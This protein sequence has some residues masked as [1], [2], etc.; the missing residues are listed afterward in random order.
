MQMSFNPCITL[1]GRTSGRFYI[2][3]L[4][5]WV[6]KKF[7]NFL[8]LSLDPSRGSCEVSK[9]VLHLGVGPLEVFEKFRVGGGTG[10]Y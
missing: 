2:V 3:W 1:V 4:Q 9:K 6:A 5:N 10:S 8:H 7:A